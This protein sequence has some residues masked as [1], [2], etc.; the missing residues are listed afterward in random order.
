[1]K[2]M[3]RFGT[4]ILSYEGAC[5]GAFM[6][7]NY[8]LGYSGYF[9]A[10]QYASGRVVIAIMT[11]WPLTALQSWESILFDVRRHFK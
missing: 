9:E 6:E 3:E 1:M 11:N 7:E 2:L 8:R 10:A 5:Q 4:P